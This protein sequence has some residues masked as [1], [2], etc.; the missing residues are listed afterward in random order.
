MNFTFGIITRGYPGTGWRDII[1]CMVDSI[2]RQGIPNYEIIIVGGPS[3]REGRYSDILHIKPDIKHF[4]FDEDK[5]INRSALEIPYVWGK[6][7]ASGGL[8]PAWTSRKKN[9]ITENAKYENIVFLHDYICLTEGWYQGFLKFGNDWD[10]CMTKIKN[11]FGERFRD[12][13]S[14]DCP[15]YGKR[16]LIPY[17]DNRPEVVKHTF[18]AGGYWVAKK[19]VMEKEPINENIFIGGI[20]IPEEDKYITDISQ[21]K[22]KTII[23]HNDVEWSVRIREKY[24]Y[25]MNPYSTVRHIRVKFTGDEQF[26]GRTN[27]PESIRYI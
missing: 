21:I 13:V 12:W 25:V 11:I 7:E 22:D 26:V 20:Y 8:A 4:P 2:R 27:C 24:K 5:I 16:N 10:V 6:D 19:Y 9:I 15:I 1:L 14:W 3:I 18:I 23:P 17:D